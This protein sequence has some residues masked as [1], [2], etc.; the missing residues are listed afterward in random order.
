MCAY[1]S[2][3]VVY[4]RKNEQDDEERERNVC[5]R[6]KNEIC[7]FLAHIF[8]ANKPPRRFPETNLAAPRAEDLKPHPIFGLNEK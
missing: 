6:F 5:S 8:F 1:I 2:Y 4:G 7:P 3:L